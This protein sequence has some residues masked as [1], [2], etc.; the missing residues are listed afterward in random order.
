MEKTKISAKMGQK[1]CF[2][3]SYLIFLQLQNTVNDRILQVSIIITT[4][5]VV[6]MKSSSLNNLYVSDTVTTTAGGKAASE[7]R[8]TPARLNTSPHFN[9]TNPGVVVNISRPSVNP[10]IQHT[11]STA[12]LNIPRGERDSR[13]RLILEMIGGTGKV[14]MEMEV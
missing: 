1:F 9:T 4:F 8:R 12:T 5:P 11:H 13:V 14:G 7:G 6:G 3:L 10:E 2:K